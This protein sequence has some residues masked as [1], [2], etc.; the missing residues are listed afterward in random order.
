MYQL[1]RVLQQIT[2]DC[3]KEPDGVWNLKIKSPLKLFS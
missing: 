1:A 2:R 3:T